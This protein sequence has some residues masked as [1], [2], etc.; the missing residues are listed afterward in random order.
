VALA[1]I[2]GNKAQLHYIKPDTMAKGIS[3]H[4]GIDKYDNRAYCD[5]YRYHLLRLPNCC[6]DAQAYQKFAKPA[7]FDTAILLNEQAT[8]K[9]L[10]H[11]IDEIA[12]RMQSG[13][14]FFLSFSGHGGQVYDK[15]GDE[16]RHQYKGYE[17]DNKDE[18]WCLHDQMVIDDELFV[19]LGRFRPGVRLLVVSDSCHSGSVTKQSIPEDKDIAATGLLMAACQDRES[20]LAGTRQEGNSRF[21]KALLHVLSQ[22]RPG[23]T[24]RSLHESVARLMPAGSRPNLFPFGQQAERLIQS[25]PFCI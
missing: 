16:Q 7:G 11:G 19:A 12:R 1:T 25:K 3:L 18:T 6:N 14:L 8:A 20:A 17:P 23:E 13:D 9:A 5:R 2:L 4:I 24:Y 21:T 15:D 22:K 10:L